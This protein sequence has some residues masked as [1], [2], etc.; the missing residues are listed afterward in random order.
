MI[1][2]IRSNTTA[3]AAAGG[4]C[5]TAMSSN[6]A[7]T[8]DAEDQ[9]GRDQA[10]DHQIEHHAVAFE[11]LAKREEWRRLAGMLAKLPPQLRQVLMLREVE[12]MPYH[13]IAEVTETPIG[14]V[15]SRLARARRQLAKAVEQSDLQ[16]DVPARIKPSFLAGVV[17]AGG[18]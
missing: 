13:E 9:P 12:D 1:T 18:D 10:A 16:K 4:Y 7:E 5:S 15:M 8:T 3:A 17:G 6:N 2:T 11:A 14:T